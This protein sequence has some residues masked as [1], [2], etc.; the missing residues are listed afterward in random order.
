M[1]SQYTEGN[2]GNHAIN[3]QPNKNAMAGLIICPYNDRR[4][5]PN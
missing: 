3:R 2:D 4:C 5:K 1:S